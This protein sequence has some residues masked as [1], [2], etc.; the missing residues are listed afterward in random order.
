VTVRTTVLFTREVENEIQSVTA[1]FLSHPQLVS[2]ADDYDFDQLLSKSDQRVEDFNSR[3]SGFIFD[4]V[5]SFTL[6]VTQYRPLAGATYLPTP[7]KIA[8][9][10]AVI[11]VKNSH[12]HHHHHL[13]NKTD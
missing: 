4:S 13:F 3:G 7:A 11:N 1:H 2:S 9:K 6:V 5:T 10:Q 12:H 8:K